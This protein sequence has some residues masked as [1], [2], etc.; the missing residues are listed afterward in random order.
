VI[1]DCSSL[2]SLPA[3]AMGGTRLPI[4]VNDDTRLASVQ[5]DSAVAAEGDLTRGGILFQLEK[6]GDGSND[7]TTVVDS[8]ST[9]VAAAST[10]ANAT[11]LISTE[12]QRSHMGGQKRIAIPGIPMTENKAKKPKS[13][14]M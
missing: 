2:A 9:A 3:V 1:G 5:N 12:R 11:T 14:V 13:E 4:L 7:M 6:L 10:T 8:P